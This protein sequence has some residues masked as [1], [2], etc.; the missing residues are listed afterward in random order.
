MQTVILAQKAE[1]GTQP[2]AVSDWRWESL[3]PTQTENRR[4][5]LRKAFN[6]KDR[7]EKPQRA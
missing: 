5:V 2:S 6:R 1:H 4:K 7:K 3:A